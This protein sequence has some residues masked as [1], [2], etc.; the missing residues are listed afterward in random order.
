MVG[1]SWVLSRASVLLPTLGV[2][3]QCFNAP[4]WKLGSPVVYESAIMVTAVFS[5]YL[6]TKGAFG[7]LG[8]VGDDELGAQEMTIESKLC[9]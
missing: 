8:E 5:S 3:D 1:D 2:A 9:C 6:E 7:N 4:W